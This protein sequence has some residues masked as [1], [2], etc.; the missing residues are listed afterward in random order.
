MTTT[1]VTIPDLFDP[2]FLASVERLKLIARRV[3]PSGSPAEKR[4]KQQG[5]G[6]EFRDYRPY[7]PGDDIKAIDWNVY[8]RLGKVFLRLFEEQRDL[9]VYV[10][11]DVSRSMFHG[12]VPRIDACLRAAFAFA[13]IALREAD[14]VGVFPFSDTLD[15]AL[16]P[17]SG[18][19][20][21]LRVATSLTKVEPGG[22]TDFVA[23][24]RRFSAMRLRPGLVVV[25]SDFFD[26][27]GLEGVLDAFRS[28]Q[29]RLCFV[30]LVRK[31]D[32][33]PNLEGELLLQDCESGHESEV[34]ITPAVLDAYREL[35]RKF[36]D[37]M[38]SFAR[39]RHAGLVRIDVEDNVVDQL[40]QLF[41]SG[42]YVL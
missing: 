41:E 29:H 17:G 37:G 4:S 23:A 38:T 10:V 30:Q 26:R 1:S 6:M 24:M 14:S 31:T 9:P 12:D 22:P 28:V 18:S 34:S 21:L 33:Q 20:R 11:P 27:N 15:V 8:R 40:A 35:Y 32:A 5:S 13:A 25:V 42:A 36:E 7:S 16:R 2:E 39:K 19:G 3:A